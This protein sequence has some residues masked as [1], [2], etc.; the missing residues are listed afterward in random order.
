MNR[1]DEGSFK[2]CLGIIP[3]DLWRSRRCSTRAG[4]IMHY[5]M[6]NSGFSLMHCRDCAGCNIKN[7]N[8]TNISNLN[9]SNK[10]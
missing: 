2:H 1:L 4:R 8:N 3:S 6:H 5:C 7:N 9:Y 10:E